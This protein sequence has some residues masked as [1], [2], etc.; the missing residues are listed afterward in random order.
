MPIRFPCPHC[1]QKLSISSKR[2][3]MTATCPRCQKELTVP[4][5][6]RVAS[7]AAHTAGQAAASP[8]AEGVS[9]LP[10]DTETDDNPY[11]QFAV[12]DETELV[13]DAPA[14]HPAINAVPSTTMDRRILVPRYVLLTQGVLLGI[15]ALAAFTLGLLVGASLFSQPAIAAGQPC[16]VNGTISYASGTGNMPDAGAVVIFLPQTRDPGRRVSAQG[17]R[18]DEAVPDAPLAAA[19]E[20]RDMGGAYTRADEQGRY[21]VQLADRGTYYVLVISSQAQRQAGED[22]NTQDLVKINRFVENAADL[23]ADS[24]YQ[25]S[26]E[27]VRGDRQFSAVLD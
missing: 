6:E 14:P 12:F 27:S 19:Q 16:K 8:P 10:E 18:P 13:C 20:L 17:L 24:R 1:R 9:P 5:A 26:T 7:A 22:V 4:A 25:F 21:E 3:G 2:A 15:V 23:L 11:A